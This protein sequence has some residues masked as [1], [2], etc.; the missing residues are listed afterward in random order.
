LLGGN[1]ANKKA[2]ADAIKGI[3]PDAEIQ[4]GVG[5]SAVNLFSIDVNEETRKLLELEETTRRQNEAAIAI[6]ERDKKVA[7][8]L[9]EGRKQSGILAN[10]AAEDRIKRV[11]LPIANT[12]GAITVRG[13]EAYENNDTVTVFAPGASGASLM[14]PSPLSPGRP[15]PAPTTTPAP[16]PTVP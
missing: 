6:A 16:S 2:L 8:L 5:I 9:A 12:P 15:A 10:D 1:E 3:G 4:I 7:I 11:I 14:I 13:L